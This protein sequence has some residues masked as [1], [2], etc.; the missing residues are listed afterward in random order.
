MDRIR[1]NVDKLLSRR[2]DKEFDSSCL[3][4][5][6]GEFPPP[7]TLPNSIDETRNEHWRRHASEPGIRYTPPGSA[8]PNDEAHGV[9]DTN[10]HATYSVRC[11]QHGGLVVKK[12]YILGKTDPQY[13]DMITRI[14]SPRWGSKAFVADLEKNSGALQDINEQFRHMC[15]GL[16]L[17]SFYETMKTSIG[18]GIKRLIVERD[19]AL[20]EYPGETSSFL[21]AD[22]HGMAKFKDPLDANFTNVT[23]VLR[24]L[25]RPMMGE[26][27]AHKDSFQPP[28]LL[29]IPFEEPF[30]PTTPGI[31]Q[32][33]LLTRLG[34][35]LGIKNDH[36]DEFRLFSEKLHRGSCQWLLQRTN[37]QN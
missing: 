29:Q 36:D 22:H 30:R 15:G 31:D 18:V 2:S 37:F 5:R 33:S 1:K 25:T 13:T 6:P 3:S 7:S 14:C 23:N 26:K 27:H 32:E 16:E 21:M 28:P 10:R 12:A 17:V 11:S 34:V 9:S 4:E 20:L 24:F 8:P 35:I 19:S